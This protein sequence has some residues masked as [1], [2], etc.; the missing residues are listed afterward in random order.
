MM[1]LPV[2]PIDEA[3]ATVSEVGRA[4]A[5]TPPLF[6]VLRTVRSRRI[7]LGYHIDAGITQAHPV[8]GREVTVPDGPRPFVSTDAVVPLTETEE[9]LIAWAACGAQRPRY[10]GPL[11]RAGGRRA[12]RA[13][14]AHRATR[15]QRSRHEPG[16]HQ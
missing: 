5:T 9:A 12:G 2:S 4:F 14:R 8:T 15:W 10:V 6:E 11:V 3:N 7:G 1:K 13:G 16:D